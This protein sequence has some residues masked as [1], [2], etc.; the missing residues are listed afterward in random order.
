MSRQQER[1]DDQ[2]VVGKDRLLVKEAKGEWGNGNG[3]MR[4]KERKEKKKKRDWT[5]GK[6]YIHVA[7]MNE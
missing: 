1:G 7:R 5:V 6:K 4:E 3:M 2:D